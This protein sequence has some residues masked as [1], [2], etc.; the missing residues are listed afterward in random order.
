MKTTITLAAL[1]G[2]LLIT[3]PVNAS[4]QFYK[5]TDAQG[6]THYTTD[7]PPKNINNATEVKIGTKL[8]SGSQE[9]SEPK[10]ADTAKAD[11]KAEKK[12]KEKNKDSTAS[13]T[14]NTKPPAQYAEK[15]KQLQGNLQ[16]LQDHPLVKETND[17]GDVTVLGGDEKQSRL[18]ETQR[19]IKAFCQ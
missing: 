17:K 11:P 6:A 5:W 9:A 8:P 16:A 3:T 15:C 4:E 12:D 2:F 14:S 1:L 7:P 18:D 19:Q 13:K 10:K